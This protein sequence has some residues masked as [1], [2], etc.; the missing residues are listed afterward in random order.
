M[1]CTSLRTRHVL[2]L[3]VVLASLLICSAVSIGQ[4]KEQL[5]L[6]IPFNGYHTPLQDHRLVGAFWRV[7]HTFE[8]VLTIRNVVETMPVT[9]TPVLILPDGSTHALQSITLQPAG[10]ASINLNRALSSLALPAAQSG[11]SF[12]TIGLNYSWHWDGAI[13]GEVQIIDSERSLSYSSGL[14]NEPKEGT[15]QKQA[16]D[17][18]WW[19]RSATSGG[20]LRLTDVA[21]EPI[22]VTANF[23][24]DNSS[25]AVTRTETLRP[26]ETKMIEL[27]GLLD[28]VPGTPMQGGLNV[29]F[30]GVSR[31]LAVDGGLEDTASGFSA[32]LVLGAIKKVEPA[33]AAS[34]Q[35][36]INLASVG[37]MIGH[38][39][40]DM[41]FPRPL[42]FHPYLVL[43]NAA[44][45]SKTVSV[46]ANYMFG[47]MAMTNHLLDVTLLAGATRKIDADTAIQGLHLN[48]LIGY[49]NLVYSFSGEKS[50]VLVSSG[51][52]DGTGTYVFETPAAPTIHS[53]SRT[54]CHW[55]L[56]DGVD[57]MFTI[58]NH[59]AV[60][61]D[62]LLTFDYDGGEYSKPVHL[63]A[64]A[65]VMLSLEDLVAR[66]DP[67]V[68]GRFLPVNLTE[69]S[70]KVSGSRSEV[71]HIDAAISV[72]SYNVNKA[73]CNIHCASCNQST[74]TG[75]EGS[76]DP[77]GFAVGTTQQGSLTGTTKSG[78]SYNL[79][80][81]VPWSS[82]NSAIASIGTGS[83]SPGL[84]TAIAPGSTT[85]TVVSPP[86]Q[87]EAEACGAPPEC[88]AA[89]PVTI[90]LPVNVYLVT[91]PTANIITDQ[92]TMT[93][94]G[95]ASA[96]GTLTV[97]LVGP[98]TTTLASVQNA[99]PG[100]QTFQFGRNSLAAGDYTAVNA[101]W[102]PNATT[103]SASAA[104]GFYSL[105][106]VHHTQYN[107][108][109]ESACTQPPA[110][111]YITQ[112]TCS[113]QQTTL[114]SD[115]M[116]QVNLN[117]G[118]V[119]N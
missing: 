22:T 29:S 55:Q 98:S 89:E 62:L 73:T 110:G 82:N 96:T 100:S 42:I 24:G 102:A 74:Y 21:A 115:F 7:D 109:Y 44:T 52:V 61:E 35:K 83:S 114:K 60:P 90:N 72:A 1:S 31:S 25:T 37:M 36:T 107:L 91:I 16:V 13:T 58:W 63:E 48:P 46:S 87:L 54:I 70:A 85:F 15:A 93:L 8:S 12:G 45:E 69:G 113:N 67:D 23:F 32:Q 39:G 95:P 79:T 64:K 97:Q 51:S 59:A 43:R 71:E 94:S 56:G 101:S 118:G 88:P 19:R 5:P 17:G 78:G 47:T 81:T 116:S 2:C 75:F 57:T 117:G 65:S 9:V 10:V 18:V 105:G 77:F 4:D 92:I 111:A 26:G 50:D 20:Y 53:M 84:G 30:E 49:I 33:A 99:V 6:L 76:P 119:W 14:R 3:S 104:V 86:L 80:S 34:P 27:K 66:G 106:V 38:P 41:M 28:A 40:A 103:Y 11:M 112:S 68:K 108:P